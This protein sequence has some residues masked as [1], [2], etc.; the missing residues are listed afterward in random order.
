MM[1]SAMMLSVLSLG[2]L[3]APA[4][5]ADLS[6]RIRG[7]VIAGAAGAVGSMVV[8]GAVNAAT[9]QTP[10]S[11]AAVSAEQPT[12]S[13]SAGAQMSTPPQGQAVANPFAR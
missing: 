11:P 7:A 4:E 2:L 12:A 3:T 13:N 8:H 6:S 9:R 5:A 10:A 1:R